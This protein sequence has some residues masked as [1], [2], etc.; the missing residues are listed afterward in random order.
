MQHDAPVLRAKL[1]NQAL[2]DKVLVDTLLWSALLYADRPYHKLVK[3]YHLVQEDDIHNPLSD[4]KLCRDLLGQEIATFHQLPPSLKDIYHALLGNVPGYAGFFDLAGY[5]PVAHRPVADLISSS[6]EGGICASVDL[7]ALVRE[8]PVELAHALALINTSDGASV[9]PGWVVNAIPHTP[10]VIHQLSFRPCTTETCSY[11]RSKLDAR[12]G[13]QD[14]FGYDDFRTF[15]GEAGM[16]IQERAVRCALDGR[17]LIAV[18]PTGGGKSLTFQLPALM[19]G[20]LTRALTVVISPLVSLMKDQVEV[21]KERFEN[22]NAVFL[23]GLLSPLERR[24]VLERIE[25][26]GAH[27]LYL[28][29][30]SL[31]SRTVERV[32]RSRNI[33]RFV[34]DEAHCFSSWGQD[35]RVDYLFIAEFMRGLQEVKGLK[36]PIPVS[37]F[38]A[39]AKPQVIADIRRYFKDGLELEL[40]E[41]ISHAQRENLSYEVIQLPSADPK[42][43]LQE[44]L[45]LLGSCKRPAIIYASRTKRVNELVLQLDKA[46]ISV[47]GFHGKMDRDEKIANQD[48]FMKGEA[49]VMVAT[50]AFGMGVDKEDVRTVIHYNISDSLEGYLQEAGRA[51]RNKAISAK[52]YILFHEEDLAKHFSLLQS[53]KLNQKQIQQIWRG[54]KYLTKYRESICPSALELA[55]QAGWE[56]EAKDLENRVT[57]ALA[58]LEDSGYLKRGF[59]APQVFATGLL[60]RDLETALKIVRSAKTITE[61]QREDCVRVLQTSIKK[62]C[63]EVD[64]L[65]DVLELK[66]RQVLETIN[67]LRG[68]KILNDAQDLSAFVD[69]RPLA[70]SMKRL[71]AL[72][73]VEKGLL[74]VLDAQDVTVSLKELNQR[75]LDLGVPGTNTADIN[76][77]LSDWDK[78][79]FVKKR[80]VK[81]EEQRY[82]IELK[83]GIEEIRAAVSSRQ[84]LALQC[85]N[86]LAGRANAS[87][88]GS[89]EE[90]R[91]EFSL[92]GLQD[93]LSA[94]LFGATHDLKALEKALLFLNELKVISL[95]GGFM[96]CYRRMRLER[97]EKNPLK[98]YTLDD[99]RK[100]RDHYRNRIQQIHVVG[101]YARKWSRDYT[102]AQ[103]FVNDYFA[104]DYKRFIGKYF[105]SRQTE[106]TR[107][108]TESRFKKLVGE[109]S[110][111]Q[112]N[113]VLDAS[114]HILVAAG[115]GSGKTR[116]LVH[117]MA[118]LLLLEDI[119]PEQF[120]MLTFSKAAALEFRSRLHEMVPEYRGLIK[121]ATFHGFCFDLL[122]QLGDL[123]KSENIIQD[124]IEAIEK[125][126]V[127]LSAVTNKSVLVLDEFQDVDA[128]QWNLIQA[129]AK[130]AELKIIAV[131]DDDQNIYEFRGASPQFMN[132]F[133]AK[134]NAKS[135]K[136]LMNYR[137]AFNLVEFTDG[138]A[139][140]ITERSKGGERLHAKDREPGHLRVVEHTAGFHLK[141]L[142]E[143]LARCQLPGTTAIL[144]RTN[145][146]ALM[147]CTMLRKAGIKA[148]TVGGSDDFKLGKLRE[149]RQFNEI[150]RNY[151]PHVGVIP[152]ELWSRTRRE[153][154]ASLPDIAIKRDLEDILEHFEKTHGNSFDLEEWRSFT[155][156]IRLSDVIDAE[157]GIVLV[158]TMH[159]S[160][161][162]EF[163]DVFVH[164]DNYRL[165]TDADTRLLY[166]ACTRA[167]KRLILHTN[168]PLQEL[169]K[170][171]GLVLNKDARSHEPP[172]ELE[173]VL[174]IK[175][176]YL[177]SQKRDQQRI[178]TINTGE[179]LV[180][181]ETRFPT[182]IA[183]GLGISP[184]G[185]VLI[186][187]RDFASG[188]LQRFVDQGYVVEDGIVEHVVELFDKELKKGYEVVLPRVRLKRSAD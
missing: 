114:P 26:G 28:A 19:Q 152:Q 178:R 156:E 120:L 71:G 123:E 165:T 171:A 30:E 134:Y 27:L 179:R 151:H 99:Y 116:V 44:L 96:V 88:E 127:D 181:D 161:G 107:P 34:I 53:T 2:D 115:P 79:G 50:T 155:H 180:P 164:L 168:S 33:A 49:D 111:E 121:I 175:E 32:L 16:G 59:N 36:R 54:I 110:V 38:T 15:D 118:H 97:T 185:N 40:D 70:G 186:Y 87:G 47:R 31:R 52:C 176:I 78:H 122:G 131:G 73:K 144:T 148:R 5:V 18:F 37:C 65:A 158:S 182:N 12:K 43:K 90:V 75:L 187:S 20:D 112:T 125:E 141:A 17:S 62:D 13:L 133:Q 66:V 157:A 46:G 100:L 106:I 108:L 61:K 35:F 104:M 6:F 60:V 154:L 117:K 80:R 113:V 92:L 81:R 86:E 95:E 3:G 85:M 39:T 126:L 21:L 172:E 101:E 184:G 64:A 56:E 23:S 83:L 105:P 63:I 159:K 162:K 138:L 183:P 10:E 69:M 7:A 142:I 102:A 169:Y 14:F 119:K 143:D 74:E 93:K 188:T 170:A 9:L 76:R 153:Y 109:L 25:N 72:L 147:A 55:R 29:P 45:R 149:I 41:Y 22:S 11:C 57:A 98:Q 1:G 51:G 68:L 167:K 8:K 137:S 150:L 136:L 94:Q 166:V 173:Y 139:H 82:R 129:I 160:K 77:L 140:Q 58:A 145:N 24:E 130:V 132:E 42:E 174:G 4:A 135:H 91:V 128:L 67:L 177:G 89:K 103:D 48:A 146:E 84:E 124:A 163:D